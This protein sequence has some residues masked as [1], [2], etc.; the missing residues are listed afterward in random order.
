MRQPVT[1]PC[2][3]GRHA[4]PERVARSCQ[5]IQPSRQPGSTLATGALRVDRR[6]AVRGWWRSRLSSWRPG[7]PP[8]RSRA[9]GGVPRSA[10]TAVSVQNGCI[11]RTVGTDCAGAGVD[12]GEHRRRI[13]AGRARCGCRWSRSAT[14]PRRPLLGAGGA[15]GAG[16]LPPNYPA[17]CPPGAGRAGP[18]VAR[19]PGTVPTPRPPIGRLPHSLGT[20]T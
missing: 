17:Q 2:K 13:M 11:A 3:T 19:Q 4:G 14:L 9:A 15:C 10:Y 18:S 12:R 7:P 8:S 6:A 20:P 5:A 1:A 16:A